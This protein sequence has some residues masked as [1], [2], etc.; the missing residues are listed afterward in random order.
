MDNLGGYR[1]IKVIDRTKIT[2][3]Q[4]NE[5][6]GSAIVDLNVNAAYIKIPFHI[7]GSLIGSTADKPDAGLIYTHEAEIIIPRQYYTPQL[8]SELTYF[9]V[10]GG[11]LVYTTNNFETF[12]L[13]DNDYPL[14]AMVEPVH[15][16]NASG[17]S[18]YRM[19]LSGKSLH[20]ALVLEE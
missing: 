19:R 18:G 7:D 2:G 13:G 12:I 20:S 15:P 8:R 4:I 11:I 16:G 10:Y 14:S 1:E 3:M 9:L 5:D 17:M 6:S